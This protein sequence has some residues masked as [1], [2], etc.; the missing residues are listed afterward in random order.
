[1][2]RK[3]LALMLSVALVGTMMV[4]CGEKKVEEVADEKIEEAV[5]ELEEAVEEELGEAVDEPADVVTGGWTV[6]EGESKAEI[7]AEVQEAFDKAMESFTG[8]ALTPVAY[9]G[10]QV[11]AGTNYQVLCT[12][13][14][15]VAEPVVELKVATI[16]ADLDGNAEVLSVADFDLGVYAEEDGAAEGEDLAGGWTV[17]TDQPAAAIDANAEKAL[18]DATADMTGAT[19]EPIALLGT[20]VVAGTNYA[21]LC[22]QTLM[23]AEATAHLVVAYVYAPVGDEA[24][25]L[26][27]A[28]TINLAD[29]NA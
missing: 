28:Y 12:G 25:E 20:Q 24:A 17:N 23:D 13:A 18:T 29:Y 7:P 4:G 21:I 11:V 9:L 8:M 2:K 1:M 19:Y 26:T 27:N 14:A 5:N 22:K 15:V 6:V 3:V 10:S 16:Y